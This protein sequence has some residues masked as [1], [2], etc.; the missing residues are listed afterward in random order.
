[1]V[2]LS[3][4]DGGL[5]V[6]YLIGVISTAKMTTMRVCCCC[7]CCCTTRYRLLDYCCGAIHGEWDYVLGEDGQKWDGYT[8]DVMGSDHVKPCLLAIPNLWLKKRWAATAGSNQRLHCIALPW[9]VGC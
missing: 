2:G 9:L 3:G 6:R 7:C 5:F 4:L 1:V 8:C